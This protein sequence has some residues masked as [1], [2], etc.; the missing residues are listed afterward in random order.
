MGFGFRLSGL[1]FR[2]SGLGFGVQEWGFAGMQNRVFGGFS[3]L[4][5]VF[6]CFR[7]GSQVRVLAPYAKL[8]RVLGSRP[9]GRSRVQKSKA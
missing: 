5:I 4:R 8:G 2:V 1:G 9:S 7:V 6:F 3:V